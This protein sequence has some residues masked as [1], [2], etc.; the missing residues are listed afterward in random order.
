V[1]ILTVGDV[2]GR[3]GR[4]AVRETLPRLREELD[5]DVVIAN[6]ENSAGGKGLTQSTA[7]EHFRAGVD[8]ITSGNHIWHERQVFP[9]LEQSVPVLRPLN[10]PPGVPGRGYLVHDL[11]PR[12]RLMVVNLCGRIELL[13]ID[14]PFR[15]M[16][17]LLE[18]M[19]ARPAII[20]VD[21]HAEATSEKAAMGWYLDGRVSAVVGTHTHVAT[22]DARILPGGT[23]F[24]SDLGMVG[25]R[26]SVIGVQ[27]APILQHFLTRMPARFDVAEGPCVFNAVLME[28]D[29]ATGK[30]KH[31]ER[32][33]RLP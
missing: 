17:H 33:D 28:I 9:Y 1:R 7:E 22:A 29:D 26:D 19:P 31:I 13:D 5:L 20:I 8:I 24:V 10:Y 15:A 25:P 23:A 6:G 2:I 11:G 21:M 4:R 12:G 3:P 30:A 16:D 18:T 27:V 14:C 32:V